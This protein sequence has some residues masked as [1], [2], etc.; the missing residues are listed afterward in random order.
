MANDCSIEMEGAMA[1][2]EAMPLSVDM[3]R[4]AWDEAT[5]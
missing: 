3:L 2:S 4:A 5:A 1:A